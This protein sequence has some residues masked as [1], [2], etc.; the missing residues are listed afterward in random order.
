MFTSLAVP[1]L[2]DVYVVDV[3]LFT[4]EAFKQCRSTI[5]GPTPDE[6]NLN[7]PVL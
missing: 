1:I 2:L 6:S 7:V 5:C 4:T 3:L